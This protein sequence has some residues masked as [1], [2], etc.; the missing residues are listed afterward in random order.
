MA[1]RGEAQLAEVPDHRDAPSD[2]VVEQS[3]EELVEDLCASG[4]QHMG[5]AALGDTTTAVGLG[6]ERVAL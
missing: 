2:Q 1:G 5:V 6:G 3:W 4:H